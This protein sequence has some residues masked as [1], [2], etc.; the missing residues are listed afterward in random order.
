[1]PDLKEMLKNEISFCES[2]SQMMETDY[3]ALYFNP[4]NPQSHDSNHAHILHLDADLEAVVQDIIRFYRG[5]NLI[6]RIYASFVDHEL[7]ILKPMLT[8]QGFKF[9]IEK[10]TFMLHDAQHAPQIDE[11]ADIRKITAISQDAQDL[12]CSDGEGGIW[13][14]NVLKI[15]VHD[16]RFHLLGLYDRDRAVS[17]ASVKILDGYSRV[18]DVETHQDFRGK[19]F[20]TKLINYLVKYHA[21]ISGN[22]L[23]LYANNPIAIRMYKGAG[24][25][26]LDEKVE[27][28]SAF[29]D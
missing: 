5:R 26:E 14:V 19:G 16:P 24:F 17:I 4:Q 6:P 25:R 12:I 20:G 18:D 15:H 9:K 11:T 22:Y 10:N 29:L 23:Y 1:M 3:G 8:E 28:W 13:T 2:F 21:D 27:N 7:E